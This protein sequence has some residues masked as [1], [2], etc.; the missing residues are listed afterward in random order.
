MQDIFLTMIVPVY[1]VER[2]LRACLDSIAALKAVEWEAILVDDGSTDGSGAICDE[3]AE[4]NARF[5]VIHQQNAGVSAARNAG[6]EAARGE[7][8][9]FV[10]SDDIV[11]VK[12][13][14]HMQKWLQQN[15]KVDYVMFDL[16]KFDDGEEVTLDRNFFSSS[17]KDG[18]N[19]IQES[20]K[21]D[22]LLKYVCA[23]HQTLWYK[24]KLIEQYHNRFTLGIRNSEDGEFMAKYLMVM[25]HPIFVDDVIYYY[26]MREGSAM[27]LPNVLRNIVEDVPVVFFNLLR[28]MDLVGQKVEPWWNHWLMKMVQNLLVQAGRYQNLDKRQFQKT[29]REILNACADKGFSFV[30]GKKMWLVYRSITAYFWVNKLYLKLK[31]L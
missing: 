14:P 30:H 28:W 18:I 21:N 16:K 9:W 23:Q 2:Y 25:K 11:D 8:I 15:S 12:C 26:R 17:R 13:V 7:W 22:F 4:Q 19:I 5:R 20:S 1:N 27:H 29:I 3:Y 10:D 31:G 6:L 24:R